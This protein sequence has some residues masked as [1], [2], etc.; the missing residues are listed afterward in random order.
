M[1]SSCRARLPLLL[2]PVLGAA[3]AQQAPTVT[4]VVPTVVV[5]GNAGSYD[6]RRDD[7]AAKI[8]V[9]SEELARYGDASV[10]D[11]L[12]RVPGVTVISTG[13]G[14]DIRLRGL[15]N[16]YTQILLNGERAPVGSSVDSLNPAQ[17]ERVEI[18]RSATAEFS[19]E[20]VAGTINIVLRKTVRTAQRQVQIGYGGTAGE[21]TP[22]AL[23]L[24]ADKN[25]GVSWSLSANSRVT[26]NSRTA[27]IDDHAETPA[28]QAILDQHTASNESLRFSTF[29]L[30]PRLN[31]TFA[32]GDS[33]AS[34]SAISY[35]KFIF[36]AL[37]GTQ[38]LLGPAP[39]FS[40]LDYRIHT[41]SFAGKTDLSYSG[42]IAQDTR[43]DVKA[44][45]QGSD[46]DND[47]DRIL[48]SQAA[49]DTQQVESSEQGFNSSGKL[50]KRLGEAHQLTAGWETSHIKRDEAVAD[51]AGGP[52]TFSATFSATTVRSAAFAQDDWTISRGWSVYLGARFERIAT[53]ID[54]DART[55][56]HAANIWSPIVQTL[57]KL[58]GLRNDRLNDQLNDQLRI[59]LTRTFKAPD[60]VNLIPRRRRYEI[61]SANN[62]D[63]EGNPLLRPEVAQGIDVTY[64]HRFGKSGLISAGLSRRLIDDYTLTA[65]SLGEDGRWL[66]RPVNA[67]SARLYGLELEA[68]F[69][70]SALSAR[71]PAIE[72]RGNFSRNWSQV[73]QVPG[74][75]NWI[76]Q[77]VPLQAML[78]ADYSWRA[79]TT[80]AS[81]VFRQGGWATV[82]A[83]QSIRTVDRTDIDLYLLWKRNA[84]D[85][86]RFTIGN[87]SGQ[88]DVSASRY[89]TAQSTITRTIAAPGNVSLRALVEHKF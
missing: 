60:T 69:A 11:A 43:L 70:L 40:E 15:G 65:I 71:L 18:I 10:A 5:T 56:A 66:G 83:A 75:H 62:A 82:T 38:A 77:Q 29:N 79:W 74:P 35:T 13:R 9:N 16:G 72:L 50:A 57:I 73:A 12:K 24:I 80:G 32:N 53:S 34:D 2:L 55:E 6:A 26:W 21:R 39:A 8:V 33:L 76:A 41:R 25:R 37:R 14:A 19:T 46:G 85:Q 64:E 81:V 84:S 54:A 89:S 58:P 36:Q 4:A 44:G 7:T 20:A 61:N 17:V 1:K 86:L 67:G 45:L 31:W 47:S 48:G 3:H 30:L 23:F 27:A 88:D 28:G 49:R 78:S 22:R 63:L 52:A 87:L 59:A 42:R 51:S 68:K